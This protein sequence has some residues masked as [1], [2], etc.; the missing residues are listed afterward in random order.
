MAAVSRPRPGRLHPRRRVVFVNRVGQTGGL[1]DRTIPP[2][3]QPNVTI[4]QLRQGK[5]AS[6][7]APPPFGWAENPPIV[8]VPVRYRASTRFRGV[9][10]SRTLWGEPRLIVRRNIDQPR[11]TR[12]AGNKPSQPTVRNRLA[13]FGSRVP[14]VNPPSPNVEQTKS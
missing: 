9:G 12:Q 4:R 10:N 5:A 13:S 7:P 8:T 11:V 14:T 1:D 2:T 3:D 6:I